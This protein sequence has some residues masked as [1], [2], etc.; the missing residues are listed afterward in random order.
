MYRTGDLAKILP[1]GNIYFL[2][3]TDFQ[4]K[5]RGFRVEVG[6]IEYQLLK[7]DSIKEAAVAAK[8]G[9]SDNQ[10]LYEYIVPSQKL[11]SIIFKSKVSL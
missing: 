4:V 11:S 7:Y 6:E 2:G 10:V 5:I 1:D 9:D 8:R 3:R